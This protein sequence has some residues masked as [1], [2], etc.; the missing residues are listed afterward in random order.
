MQFQVVNAGE[1][2]MPTGEADRA[3]AIR[4]GRDN[5]TTINQLFQDYFGLDPHHRYM[6]SFPYPDR[7]SGRCRIA[8]VLSMRSYYTRDA[9]VACLRAAIREAGLADIVV[10]KTDGDSPP[11]SATM[12]I[13]AMGPSVTD[14]LVGE[15]KLEA[16][17]KQLKEWLSRA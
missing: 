6:G 2:C 3:E 5:A 8:C 14:T 17:L 11:Y 15:R 1:Q 10:V 13:V 12:E 16:A 7:D 4:L 9:I